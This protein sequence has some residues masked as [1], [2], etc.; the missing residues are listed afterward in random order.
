MSRT[1]R[2]I[3]GDSHLEVHP[4][5]WTPRVPAEYR[6]MAP[7]IVRMPDGGDA[8]VVEG[9]PFRQ[10]AFDLYGG[11]GR[12]TWFPWGQNYDNTP[13]TSGDPAERLK[14]QDQDGIDAEVLFPN[15]AGGP[16]LWR[17]IRHED[18]Y[19]AV[20]HA[21]NEWL[22]EYCSDAPDRLLGQGLIP[23]TNAKDA[24]A[25]LEYLKKNNAAGI[26]MA[27]FPSG[28]GLPTPE[29]DTFWKTCLDMKVPVTVH[30]EF[31]REGKRGGAYLNYAKY[32]DNW[33][34]QGPNSCLAFQ[35][36]RFGRMGSLNAVQM[37]LD[38]VFDRIPNLKIFFAETQISWIPLF[39]EQADIRY[40]R[41]QYWAEN[42]LGWK[43]LPKQPTEYIR[44][45]CYWGFQ[46]D[47]AGV[48]MRHH[49]YMRPDRLIWATDFP[50][51]ES[52]FPHSMGVVDRVF[53]DVPED[54]K[55]LMTAQNVIDFFGL[56]AT[57]ASS[58][59]AKVAAT[60]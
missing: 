47:R 21:Y 50:H 1:Y 41:H 39:S 37:A 13:G 35:V 57:V 6:E 3:S 17:H 45:H 38:G 44:D 27:T 40:G 24:F 54:E 56:D 9:Q 19:R 20:I 18:A 8:W 2:Y 12:D 26:M 31:N 46:E 53:H 42:V 58:N 4:G 51:Q 23:M 14:L 36:N 22:M 32:P 55:R 34:L 43:P 60:A 59:G 10:V 30:Q 29:D 52:E 25:E 33:Y 16:N 48:E 7:S 49:K 15:Q 5:N 28:R 11:K